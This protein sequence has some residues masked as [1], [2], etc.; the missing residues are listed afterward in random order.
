[1]AK[2]RQLTTAERMAHGMAFSQKVLEPPVLLFASAW[3]VCIYL[4]MKHEIPTRFLARACWEAGRKVSVPVWSGSLKKFRLYNLQPDM[5]VITGHYGIK[6]PQQRIPANTWEVGAFIMPGLAFDIHGGRLGY[7]K[8]YYDQILQDASPT[9]QKIALCYEW[10]LMEY[11]L[12]QEEHDIRMN[13]I[14]TEKRTIKCTPPAPP[15]T[16]P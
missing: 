1:M 10:Q 9:A 2:R 8:G 11:P 12:P 16:S 7:G 13:W 6:E 5:R 14:V 4:S 15:A 3:H